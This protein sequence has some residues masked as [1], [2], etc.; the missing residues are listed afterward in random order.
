MLHRTLKSKGVKLQH[1]GTHFRPVLQWCSLVCPIISVCAAVEDFKCALTKQLIVCSAS[2][3]YVKIC[4]SMKLDF[5]GLPCTRA[6]MML[7]SRNITGDICVPA[8]L[9]RNPLPY[10]L[11]NAES[12]NTFSFPKTRQ[13]KLLYC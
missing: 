11:R 9:V 1:F 3:N 4:G 7:F 8:P 5:F 13:S 6:N 10:S 12:I 2:L